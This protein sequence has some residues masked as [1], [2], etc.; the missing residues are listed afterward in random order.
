MRYAPTPL[1]K[2]KFIYLAVYTCRATS[3]SS[4]P[5]LS[6]H[7]GVFVS[8][9]HIKEYLSWFTVA[10]ETAAQQTLAIPAESTSKCNFLVLLAM[11]PVVLLVE[12]FQSI[13]NPNSSLQI[14]F[15]I[16]LLYVRPGTRFDLTCSQFGR[17]EKRRENN[18]FQC[19][20]IT[21]EVSSQ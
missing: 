19:N 1:Y 16:S 15:S 2:D 10:S 8:S 13:D 21:L 9:F 20:Q 14:I 17:T 7:E 3:I 12:F 11:N 6:A 5:Y 18:I 4:L